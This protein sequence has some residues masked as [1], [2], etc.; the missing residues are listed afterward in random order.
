MKNKASGFLLTI[1]LSFACSVPLLA[2]DIGFLLDSYVIDRW[3]LDE[4][5]FCDKIKDLG[6]TFEVNVAYGD[7]NEQLKQAKALIEKGAK[8]LVVVPVDGE[9]AADIVKL[10]K[11]ANVKVISYDRLI[12]HPDVSLYVS[13]NNEKVGRLQARYALERVPKGNYVLLNGPVTDNNAILFREGQLKELQPAIE[14]GQIKVVAD[15]V[16]P[17]WGEIGAIM[18]MD[19]FYANTTA[20]LDVVLAAN[21]ALASGA[22]QAL[23]PTTD[24]KKMIITGQDADLTALKSI[25]AGGQS[26][27]I[28]KPIRPLAYLAAE[29]TMKLLKGETLKEAAP[30]SYGNIT[31]PSILLDPV[32]VDKSN[33]KDTV[34]KDGHV[35]LS[36]MD[37][38]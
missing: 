15:F 23:P 19:D 6:G 33:F 13:Y 20:K 16:M 2:Q 24:V 8:V 31:V 3:Y 18:Q 35:S 12:L 25:I 1:L 29:N 21:D 4:K 9:K 27:T 37:I 5:L 17:D 11:A 7:P 38:K 22:I 14:K 30:V 28:Y 32:V 10:A 36:E 26:M 34:V